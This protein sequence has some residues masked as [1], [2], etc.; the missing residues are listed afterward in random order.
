VQRTSAIRYTYADYLSIPEDTSH[1]HEIVGGE[2]FVT[3]APRARH[4]EVVVN[5]T[6]VLANLAWE[7][8]HGKVF[9]GPITVHLHDELVVE[10]DVIFVRADRLGIVDPEGGVEGPPDLVIEV[11]SPSN[12][13]YDRNLKRKHYLD[14]GVPELWI[15]DADESTVEVWTPRSAE[16]ALLR[17]TLEWRVGERGFEIPLAEVFRS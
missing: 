7:R 11:L 2:L 9:T 13:A 16:P 5:L 3:P 6:R 17:D 12:R 4:Q 1:R 10:P 14:N 15:V 8:G